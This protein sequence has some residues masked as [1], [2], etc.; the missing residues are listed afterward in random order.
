MYSYA[1]RHWA[2]PADPHVVNYAGLTP[3]TLATKLGR[4]HI[5]EEMLELMKVE[6]W[7]FSDMTCSA[8]PLNTLDTIQPDGSTNYDSALMTV[9]N[10]STAEHLDMIGSEVI[11]RLLADK[12]KAFAMR[13]LI[14]RLALLIIQLVTLSI[15]VY[16]RPTEVQRL[17]MTEP[18]WDDWVRSICEVLTIINCVFF[19]FFQQLGEI[20]TQGLAGYF[21]NLYEEFACANYEVLTK[22]LFVLYMFV[23]PI[24]MINI[25]IAMMGN[26]YTTVIAQAE[27]AWR[28]QVR[29][30]DPVSHMLLSAPSSVQEA[31]DWHPIEANAEPDVG[32]HE[33]TVPVPTHRFAPPP[34]PSAEPMEVEAERIDELAPARLYTFRNTVGNELQACKYEKLGVILTP[35]VAVVLRP[36]RTIGYNRLICPSSN[37][38]VPCDMER[39]KTESTKTQ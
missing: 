16:V 33:E 39:M 35:V 32:I 3:L 9:I 23:M 27:K 11:Q 6:F 21:R 26:T 30:E 5:F 15:V 38:I 36:C 24:M 34:P 13:K 20:R 7:R 25:L 22:T 17:Y 4:K 29:T 19:V 8:Y 1:V 2:K 12:W 37:V 18:Q 14:E 31:V 28:Q 10:G